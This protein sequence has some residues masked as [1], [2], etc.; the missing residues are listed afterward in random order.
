M[1][2]TIN[3]NPMAMNAQRNLESH[4]GDLATSTRRLSSGLRVDTAADDAAGLAVRELMRADIAA[5]NQGVRNANDGISAI[6]TADGSLEVI[7]NKLIRMKELAE[8]AATGTY[9]QEQRDV[10]DGEFQQ[11]KAE[12]NRIAN[13]TEF[14]QQKLINGNLSGDNSLKVHFGPRNNDGEDFYYV[15]MGDAT[16]RGLNIENTYL[17]TNMED[18][19]ADNKNSLTQLNDQINREEPDNPDQFMD[20][21]DSIRHSLEGMRDDLL[22]AYEDEKVT[23]EFQQL[24]DGIENAISQ[25]DQAI[26]EYENSDD[27]DWQSIDENISSAVR[28]LEGKERV[29]EGLGDALAG[30]VSGGIT[31][32]A[33]VDGQVFEYEAASGDSASNVLEGLAYEINQSDDYDARV[34]NGDLVVYGAGQVGVYELE[35]GSGDTA[36]EI[37]HDGEDT[38][39]TI[40]GPEPQEG[41]LYRLEIESGA[42]GAGLDENL[43]IDYVAREGDTLEDVMRAL[44]QQINDETDLEASY[45]SS[46]DGQITIEGE[47]VSNAIDFYHSQSLVYEERTIENLTNE[48]NPDAS[49]NETFHININGESFTYTTE[50]GDTDEDVI[51]GLVDAINESETYTASYDSDDD[52]MTIQGAATSDIAVYELS[53][54]EVTYTVDSGESGENTVEI[55]DGPL[56]EGAVYALDVGSGS[57]DNL[58]RY[59]YTVQD[60][61]DYEDIMRALAEQISVDDHIDDAY[62][63]EDE[64]VIVLQDS[65]IESGETWAELQASDRLDGDIEINNPSA[66]LVDPNLQE[67]AEEFDNHINEVK[68]TLYAQNALEEID[69]AIEIKDRIRADL[70]AYQNR[71]DNTVS[72]L[73]IQAENLQAAESRISDVDVA[74]EMTQF[75][76]NQVLSQGATAMLAQANTLPQMAMQLMG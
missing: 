64:G 56:W 37:S 30:E 59:E 14:N 25:L 36:L 1:S 66:T 7:D 55:T 17:Q 60:G 40:E 4:Y 63:D 43:N 21:L 22:T 61:D 34:E 75:T 57:V 27:I 16:A 76:R 38:N 58:E 62:F 50:S 13:Q 18:R 47:N 26:G 12:I 3:H 68:P 10:I 39:L 23:E 24:Q 29:V 53:S 28:F 44:T 20:N 35:E 46:E 65:N 51:E 19:L 15:D 73:Q 54:D 33:T 72:N 74:H 45:S 48:I 69:A 9:T 8:Q 42:D 71:L 6:Q 11:M 32:H 41:M 52:E 49:G 2:L 70:G 67:D 31:Y 5:M